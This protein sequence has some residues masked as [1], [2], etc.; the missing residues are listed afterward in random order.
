VLAHAAAVHHG[1]AVHAR[2]LF[3]LALVVPHA[4]PVP[5]RTHLFLPGKPVVGLV[6]VVRRSQRVDPVLLPLAKLRRAGARPA[7]DEPGLERTGRQFSQQTIKRSPTE[8]A[9]VA[10]MLAKPS[11]ERQS[12]RADVRIRVVPS[13][14]DFVHDTICVVRH[15]YF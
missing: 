1:T 2:D 6:R 5:T 4:V 14:H 12:A 15:I 10:I 13:V 11:A 8:L 7:L 3:A 9:T